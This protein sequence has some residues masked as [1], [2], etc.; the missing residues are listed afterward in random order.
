MVSLSV[1][2]SARDPQHVDNDTVQEWISSHVG[3]PAGECQQSSNSILCLL[4]LL[5][6]SPLLTLGNSDQQ[7]PWV[8]I[9]TGICPAP[10]PFLW[11]TPSTTINAPP[12][13]SNAVQP[14][15]LG[16]SPHNMGMLF[17]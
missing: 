9:T 3:I 14:P 15:E 16:F 2:P 6:L 12:L 13:M 5:L 17:L 7:P 8:D 11:Y 1:N 4:L 10:D